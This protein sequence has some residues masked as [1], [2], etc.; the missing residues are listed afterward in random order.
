VLLLRLSFVGG[1]NA[2]SFDGG[3]F[4]VIV[5][6]SEKRHATADRSGRADRLAKLL[7]QVRV[8]GLAFL[9]AVDLGVFQPLGK[10]NVD[11]RF[12]AEALSRHGLS[13]PVVIEQDRKPGNGER[14][15]P[16]CG[17]VCNT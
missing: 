10:G 6:W 17:R 13:G 14:R 1:Q 7:D 15:P 8:E 5:D 4:L 16:R 9:D 11:F 3:R 2:A 12:F